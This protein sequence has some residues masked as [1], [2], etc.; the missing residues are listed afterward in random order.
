MKKKTNN[1]ENT[2]TKTKHRH[3]GAEN[4]RS[5]S[6]DSYIAVKGFLDNSSLFSRNSARELTV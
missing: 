3:N 1:S 2:K 5:K 4:K 6:G